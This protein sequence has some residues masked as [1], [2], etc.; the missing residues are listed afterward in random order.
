MSKIEKALKKAQDTSPRLVPAQDSAQRQLVPV[1]ES[2]ALPAVQGWADARE[3]IARMREPR[4]LDA[5]QLERLGI[6]HAELLEDGPTKGFREIRT[7]IIQK[8][9]G[10]NCV[11]MVTSLADRREG[12]IVAV[13]L[14]A[15]F[16]LDP[17]KTAVL[18]DG[19][20]RNPSL[21]QLLEGGTG[22]GLT[23]YL[24]DPDMDVTNI[25]HAVGIPRL[26]VIPAGGR[27]E[28]PTEY[29]TSARMQQLISSLR[30]RYAERYVV[31]DAPP[32]EQSA[33]TPILAELCD[34]V[35]LVVPYG[36]VSETKLVAAAR[37]IP[38]EKFLGVIF[39][40]VPRLPQLPWKEWLSA[41]LTALGPARRWLRRA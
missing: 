29:F 11:V 16:A 9:G 30:R 31:L 17:G 3:A 7:K 10:K 1:A 40:D 24:E 21:D 32:V 5:A 15:A 19:N 4:L 26:R 13:N 14:A 2:Q 12:G 8:T 36:R 20:L 41:F 35:L 18:I 38:A 23:D 37:T 34:F 25:M 27:R 22:A 28:I 33:D 6:I 39:D